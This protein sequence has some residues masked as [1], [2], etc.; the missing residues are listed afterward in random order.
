MDSHPRRIQAIR[1]KPGSGVLYGTIALLALAFLSLLLI[2]YAFSSFSSSL[3]GRCVAV[4]EISTELTVDGIPPSLFDPGLPGSEQIAGRIESVGARDDVGA[5]VI[6][7]NS[8]GGSV[9][10]T[11]EI[12]DS[13]KSLDKPK[14]A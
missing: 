12:Y 11:R 8:P 9:V 14:V 5:L 7:I 3:M 2:F 13:V 10:A 1:Q 6:V 4:T